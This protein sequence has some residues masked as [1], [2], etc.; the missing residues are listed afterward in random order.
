MME[1]WRVGV[2]PL[3]A[4]KD[5]RGWSLR[6]QLLYPVLAEDG[7]S[8]IVDDLL[9]IEDARRALFPFPIAFLL[10]LALAADSS[11]RWAIVIGATVV[12]M[13]ANA[14]VEVV[15]PTPGRSKVSRQATSTP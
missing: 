10:P 1:K 9:R 13:A 6:G 12:T 7:P 11:A 2:L 3:D 5:K 8:L 4:G 15:E 14:V